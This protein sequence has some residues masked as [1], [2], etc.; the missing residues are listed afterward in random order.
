MP[1]GS[2]TPL[3]KLLKAVEKDD[4]VAVGKYF[5]SGNRLTKEEHDRMFS[6]AVRGNNLRVVKYFLSLDNATPGALNA[7]VDT[8]APNLE[9]IQLLLDHGAKATTDDLNTI[10]RRSEPSLEVIELLLDRGASVNATTRGDSGPIHWAIFK[11]KLSVIELLVK[12]GANAS[13]RS[14]NGDTPLCVALETYYRTTHRSLKVVE[15]L[16]EEAKCNVNDRNS[17]GM[18]PLYYAV[19]R[20]SGEGHLV[21]RSDLGLVKLFIRH[22]AD[23][24]YKCSAIENSPRPLHFAVLYGRQ[25][26]VQ[27]LLESGADPNGSAKDGRTPL[28]CVPQKNSSCVD[29][30]RVL[31]DH[32]ADV[33]AVDDEGKTP[34]LTVLMETTVYDI[35]AIKL[36]LERGADPNVRS[37]AGDTPIRLA[38][39]YESIE[40]VEL[41]SNPLFGLKSLSLDGGSHQEKDGKPGVPE[42]KQ[43]EEWKKQRG[44]K[45]NSEQER[46]NKL[47]FDQPVWHGATQAVST[48]S[49][50]AEWLQD[51]QRLQ[52]I[53]HGDISDEDRVKIAIIDSGLHPAHPQLAL[54]REYK[55]FITQ[56]KILVD[57]TRH[58]STGV[59]LIS[60]IAPDAD[61]YVAR[62]FKGSDA[63]ADTPDLISQ[64]INH[65]VN[66]W[67]VDIISLASGLHSPHNGIRKAVQA[68][69]NTIIFA[70]A[71]NYGSLKGIA[72]PAVMYIKY[73]LM[74]MFACSGM[75]KAKNEFNP[76]TLSRDENNFALL[77][78]NVPVYSHLTEKTRSGTS[79]ATFIG[80]AV[81]AL[82][83]DFA[84]QT[85]VGA[86]EEELQK[87]CTVGGMTA[88][89]KIM[90][91]RDADYNC[92]IPS[93]LLEDLSIAA[94]EKTRKKIWHRIAAALDKVKN[95]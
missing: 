42:L 20:E 82:L 41:L 91:R 89:F 87:L 33:N 49:P 86:E 70:A 23:I 76:E 32:G 16:L 5:S 25:D 28:H 51:T 21:P 4:E 83:L 56:D 3:E 61:I 8:D 57:E 50:A 67:K 37:A 90:S 59:D 58:G 52:Y 55:D 54:V 88:V 72:F 60:E 77:G 18:T 27:L 39:K 65:A 44:L 85:E 71:A 47:N 48:S 66:V 80:A 45:R 92:V 17:D 34:L 2:K 22:H 62:V 75:G 78:E 9:L 93:I 14:E 79:Y 63:E 36:L 68:A 1:F 12:R 74:C 31:L 7:A 46:R 24:N 64:A 30:V 40:L 84:R 6:T 26:L 69:E 94:R 73:S 11:D 13:L 95:I 15:Y 81:A 19:A 10:A 29:L 38:E 53:L 35:G 43:A